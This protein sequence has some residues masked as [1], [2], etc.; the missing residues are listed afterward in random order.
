MDISSHGDIRGGTHM[1][2]IILGQHPLLE[3]PRFVDARDH[4]DASREENDC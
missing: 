1:S 4:W 2:D 3:K